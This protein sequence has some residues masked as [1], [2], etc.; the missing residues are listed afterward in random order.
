[1]IPIAD[2]KPTASAIVAGLTASGTFITKDTNAAA[3]TPNNNP[4]KPP[5]RQRIM[6][7]VRN[8]NIIVPVLAPRAFLIPIS[9]VR[10]VM[11]TSIIF[12]TPIPPTIS[13]I[14]LTAAI[15]IVKTLIPVSRRSIYVAIFVTA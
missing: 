14:A 13:E 10:S 11:E 15:N 6:D 8:W 3:A 5:I 12:I 2:E 1:M 7:S 9:R 4:I